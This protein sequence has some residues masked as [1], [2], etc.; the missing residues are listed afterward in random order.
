MYISLHQGIN[1][2]RSQQSPL[3][4]SDPLNKLNNATTFSFPATNTSYSLK[5]TIPITYNIFSL[6]VYSLVFHT[7]FVISFDKILF[8]D[9]A[10]TLHIRGT[11]FSPMAVGHISYKHPRQDGSF[12]TNNC[13]QS[14]IM[15]SKIS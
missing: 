14:W 15:Q 8:P 11:I 12:L 9:Y 3:E 6:W 10:N 5:G 2:I 1:C 7:E 4:S 13:G